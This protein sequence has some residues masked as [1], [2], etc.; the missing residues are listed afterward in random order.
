MKKGEATGPALHVLRGSGLDTAGGSEFLQQRL[1]SYGGII[2]LA[3]ALW[4]LT[5]VA[6][7][8]FIQNVPLEN[9]LVLYRNLLGSVVAGALW[10]VCRRW[11][12]S[13][14]TLGTLDVVVTFLCCL[15]W[16]I[17]ETGSVQVIDF[18]AGMFTISLTVMTRAAVVPSKAGRT[19]RVTALACLPLYGVLAFAAD[20]LAQQPVP[21]SVPL[22]V[23][24]VL[25]KLSVI[26]IALATVTSRIIYGLRKSVHEANQL[27]QYTLEERLGVGGMGEVW[28]AR[29]RLLMRPAAVKIIRFDPERSGMSDPQVLLRRFEREAHATAALKSPHTVVLYDFGQADDGTLYYV[30]ELLDGLDLE[31]MVQRFGPLPAERAI[32]ILK[33][34]CHSLG[35]A[36]QNG[37]TH[38]DIKP[39]NVFV[40]REG[41]ELDFAKVL[42]FGLVRLARERP[43]ADQ[44]KLTAQGQIS[45]TPAYMAPEMVLGEDRYD[46]RIDIYAVGC[47]AYWLVTGKLVFEG[48]TAMKI[49]LDHLQTPPP[50]PS[51]RTELPIP[52][53]LEQLILACLEK[54]PERR[55]ASAAELAAG[56]AAIP[57]AQA[58]SCERAATWWSTQVPH[59]TSSRPVADALLSREGMTVPDTHALRPARLAGPTE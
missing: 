49:M 52:P 12:L 45:G 13:M 38:R 11:R 2:A 30:M 7:V 41:T 56:L 53:E 27:G 58:W 35:E 15:A 54:D 9:A 34:V 21:F 50:P 3:S 5:D 29:H 14:R 37:L 48:P 4:M 36:H 10:F 28:R 18:L 40:S 8:H 33:Q 51:K 23:G 19:A 1:G 25:F 44:M 6:V 22:V 24:L 39:A 26:V 17:P 55:P 42:D 43:S 46:H 32:H 31:T 20:F 47:V 16:V 57:L 59:Q